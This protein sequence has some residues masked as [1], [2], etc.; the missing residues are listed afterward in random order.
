M[1]IYSTSRLITRDS[2]VRFW[3]SEKRDSLTS[4]TPLIKPAR[5]LCLAEVLN[6]I[7]V[8]TRSNPKRDPLRIG[9]PFIKAGRLAGLA[10]DDMTLL[11]IQKLKYLISNFVQSD[12]M[13]CKLIRK[14]NARITNLFLLKYTFFWGWIGFVL[15]CCN[16]NTKNKEEQQH[17]G[18]VQF[19]IALPWTF[20]R[21][22]VSFFNWPVMFFL[23]ITPLIYKRCHSKEWEKWTSGWWY[24]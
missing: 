16:K 6:G 8:H 24:F 4:C 5:Q 1:C 3:A 14:C 2:R 9:A 10:G 19:C 22:G 7:G 17:N 12:R 20:L 18:K 13:T 15:S 23:Q 21:W 11:F